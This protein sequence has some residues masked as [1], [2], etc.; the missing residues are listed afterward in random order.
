MGGECTV[1]TSIRAVRQ[2]QRAKKDP[3][4]ADRK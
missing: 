2:K 1:D 3:K 4:S